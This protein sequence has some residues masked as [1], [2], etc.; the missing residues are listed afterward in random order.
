[1]QLSRYL[2]A[3]LAFFAVF[4]CISARDYYFTGTGSPSFSTL[5]N[6]HLDSAT[7]AIATLLPGSED[8]VYITTDSTTKVSFDLSLTTYAEVI[9]G[10]NTSG[11]TNTQTLLLNSNL[12]TSTK[13]TVQNNGVLE[14]G[15]NGSV[16]GTGAILVTAGGK[17]V[18]KG[19]VSASASITI[20]SDAS[21]DWESGSISGGSEIVV[22]NGA[23]FTISGTA[24]RTISS[25]PI[26]LSGALKFTA[27]GEPV[28]A[29][30]Q[31]NV[32]SM[33][34]MDWTGSAMINGSGG[35]LVE[36]GGRLD[37]SAATTAK[38]TISN[39]GEIILRDSRILINETYTQAAATA[40]TIIRGAEIFYDKATALAFAAGNVT[41]SG[42]IHAAGG[43][44][45]KGF[46]RGGVTTAATRKRDDEVGH[47]YIYGNF[48]VEE[49]ANLLVRA[50]SSDDYD[51]ITVFGE[52]IYE[53]D[54]GIYLRGLD[55]FIPK[56]GNEYVVVKHSSRSGTFSRFFAWGVLG[57]E[58]LHS[59]FETRVR[60][61]YSIAG[62]AATFALSAATLVAAAVAFLAM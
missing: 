6:W 22:D 58:I 39:Q 29:N 24:A 20:Q 44:S 12:S 38:T 42:S 62:G 17:I 3:L 19:S 41:M 8:K 30:S 28:T 46:F 60:I 23:Q 5:T 47:A 9:V 1:M 35:L 53:D 61:T 27:S 26:R 31:I 51:R 50:K 40:H 13:L 33:G 56:T 4:N 45:V 52:A 10:S 34:R 15:S 21:Y 2:I 49:G 43:V 37:I 54:T 7:G 32:K 59:N 55:G 14:I 25:K 57:A 36:M 11:S 18:Q 16:G 48:K